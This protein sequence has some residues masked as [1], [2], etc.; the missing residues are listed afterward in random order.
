MYNSGVSPDLFTYSSYRMFLRDWLS[1]QPERTQQQLASEAG[2]S[3][4]MLSLILNGRRPL[5][6][7]LLHA[8]PAALELS[9]EEHQFFQLLVTFEQAREDSEERQEAWTEIA[10]VLKLRAARTLSGGQVDTLDWHRF[11]VYELA[12][13]QD[14][15]PDLTWI[16]ARLPGLSA[17]EVAQAVA[18]LQAAGLMTEALHARPGMLVD[19]S[20]D[21]GDHQEALMRLHRRALALATA[22]LAVPEDEREY[23]SMT[24]RVPASRLPDAIAQI[25]MMQNRV[26]QLCE[27]SPSP[28]DPE[29]VY[30]FNIQLFPVS[31]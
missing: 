18:S 24:V 29:R 9:A 3:A 12:Q 7:E 20:V 25:R 1:A 4:A 8:L 5:R 13:C 6:G 31:A 11:F 2:C 16:A 15:Q 17:P 14:Y 26:L 19:N 21:R 27:G 30:L 28:D 10:G 23:R 22:G